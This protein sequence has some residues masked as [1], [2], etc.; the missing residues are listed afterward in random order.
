MNF[1]EKL[2][3]LRKNRNM[4]QEQLAEKLY[5]SRQAVTKWENGTGLPDIENI[6]AISELFNES[7]DSLLSE[8]KSLMSKN[9]F[10]Y[11]SSTKYDLENAKEIEF[12]FDI[13]HEV[14][15]ERTE[16][17]QIEVVLASNRLSLLSRL[18]KVKIEENRKRMT[19]KI[20]HSDDIT[21][22]TA[23]RD[24]YVLFRI[25]QKFVAHLEIDG[26]TENLRIRDISLESLEF[27]GKVKKCFISNALGHVEM[28]TG[29]DAVYE[30]DSFKGKL[31]INQWRAVSVISVKNATFDCR[32]MG[33]HTRF[34]DKD[35]QVMD[36]PD[37]KKLKD[38]EKTESKADFVLETAGFK[39]EL[40]VI[41]E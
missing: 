7:I 23:R 1:A 4:S 26:I 39:S 40:K 25:P 30:V 10:L 16:N 17:E 18:A 28:D 14:I 32:R 22:L 37:W 6:I 36:V 12:L 31:D 9:D 5:V 21:D 15:V 2:R 38:E 27:G 34:L 24:I 41:A 33:K 8:E 29:S 13:A 20:K 19:V 3:E 35:N 11:H